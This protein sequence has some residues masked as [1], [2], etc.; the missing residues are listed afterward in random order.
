[1]R[2]CRGRHIFCWRLLN[3]METPMKYCTSC[4]YCC[5][6]EVNS[7]DSHDAHLNENIDEI[8]ILCGP[9]WPP[10]ANP[11]R[12]DPSMVIINIQP[13]SPGEHKRQTYDAR[14]MREP[15]AKGGLG[16]TWLFW[17]SKAAGRGAQ[18][19]YRSIITSKLPMCEHTTKISSGIQM[20]AVELVEH[21]D[22]KTYKWN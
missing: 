7:L 11:T 3:C 13:K 14:M 18:G 12:L 15:C 9:R 16:E 21:T 20:G 19:A 4:W 2:G 6:G 22:V 5:P 17:N 10:V 1:M 8:W